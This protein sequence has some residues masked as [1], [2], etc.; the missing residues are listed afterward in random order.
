MHRAVPF[1]FALATLAVAGST[2]ADPPGLTPS[3]T[4]PPQL[5]EAVV[6]AAAASA[7][8]QDLSLN[9]PLNTPPRR[10]T[11]SYSGTILRLDS[12]SLGAFLLGVTMVLSDGSN[13]KTGTI[14]VVAAIP[15]WLLAAPIV[16][17]MHHQPGRVVGSVA[18]RLLLPSVGLA[19][20][21]KLDS[22]DGS[23]TLAGC[24]LGAIAATA[25]DAAVA[26]QSTW[27]PVVAP[28]QHGGATLG[29]AGRW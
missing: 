4:S 25:I 26:H 1:V 22:G 23:D 16:H 13:Q 19:I 10:F 6:T 11:A 27:S 18:L 20:G 14:L 15:T 5:S 2:H 24:L 9:D 29:V 8:D 7:R 28:T 12:I 21:S 3:I 17:G